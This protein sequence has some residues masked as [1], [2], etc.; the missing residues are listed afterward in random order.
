MIREEDL[1]EAIAECEGARSP[2]AS[3]CVKLAAYYTLLNHKFRSNEDQSSSPFPSYS[4]AQEPDIHFGNSE[5]SSVVEE[6]GISK[7]FPIIDEMM[8][9]LEMLI[10]KLYNATMRKLEEL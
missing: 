1:R 5:F 9:A 3:T 4:F 2:T 8:G 7:C 6:K 10:P